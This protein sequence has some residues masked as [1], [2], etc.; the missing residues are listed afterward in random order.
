MYIVIVMLTTSISSVM[1]SL[2][3]LY[4]GMKFLNQA[5]ANLI[6]IL[7]EKPLPYEKE[8]VDFPDYGIKVEHVSFEYEKNIDVLKDI[9]FDAPAGTTTALIGPSGSGKSTVTN[10]ISRFWDVT[11][12][13]ISIGGNDIKVIRPDTL[14]EH[15]A[16]VFQDVY[17]LKD[18]IYNNIRLGRPTAS[19][20]DVINAAKAAHCHDFIMNMENGY[21]TV[22]GE[23]GSTLSGGEKQ[24]IS[25][26][27]ALVK[28]AP[29]VLLDESTS[30][31]DADNEAEINKALDTL[32]KGKTVIVIAHRLNTIINADNIIVLDSGKIRESGNHQDLMETGGWYAEMYAEQ[33]KALEWVVG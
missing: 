29:I 28:D 7:D 8:A 21:D 23:G 15:M 16:V 11:Q 12:G 33:Q 14:T 6:T 9:T 5:S 20:E 18:S 30:S 31:L 22:V 10:L 27:R 1:S 25:I 3:S 26:A 2:A 24:R 19:K 32:M 13:K 4:T 17:L